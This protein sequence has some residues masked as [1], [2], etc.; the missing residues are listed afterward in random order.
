MNRAF[1]FNPMEKQNFEMSSSEFKPYWSKI[2]IEEYLSS[3]KPLI[4]FLKPCP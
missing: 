1:A 3:T 4:N 2:K